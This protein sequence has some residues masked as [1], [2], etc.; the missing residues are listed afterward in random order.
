MLSSDQVVVPLRSID[1]GISRWIGVVVVIPENEGELCL[2]TWTRTTCENGIPIPIAVKRLQEHLKFEYMH[3]IVARSLPTLEAEEDGNCEEEK[4]VEC[5]GVWSRWSFYGMLRFPH[6]V[7]F[8]TIAAKCLDAM[9]ASSQV[10]TTVEC[11]RCCYVVKSIHFQIFDAQDT[12]KPVFYSAFLQNLDSKA[13]DKDE[14]SHKKFPGTIFSMF[15]EEDDKPPQQIG[16]KRLR[17]FQYDGIVEDMTQKSEAVSEGTHQSLEVSPNPLKKA[18]ATKHD[19]WVLC[20]EVIKAKKNVWEL[21]PHILVRHWH[22]I[23]DMMKTYAPSQPTKP[24]DDIAQLRDSHH[25][26]GL[27]IWGKPGCGKS[28]WVRSYLHKLGKSYY[29]KDIRNHWF[30]GYTDQEVIFL[31]DFHRTHRS[32]WG[33]WL[34]GLVNPNLGDTIVEV[35]GSSVAFKA[36]YWIVTSNWS[37]D[38]LWASDSNDDLLALKRR[39]RQI[40]FPS[41]NMSPHQSHVHELKAM[42]IPCMRR[43]LN[44]IKLARQSVCAAQCAM[45]CSEHE[46]ALHH[47]ISEELLRIGRIL[48]PHQRHGI[49]CR[50]CRRTLRQKFDRWCEARH[51]ESRFSSRQ[52]RARLGTIDNS[53]TDHDPSIQKFSFFDDESGVHRSLG[54]APFEV[55]ETGRPESEVSSDEGQMRLK[56][57]RVPRRTSVRSNITRNEI[58]IP[59]L[60]KQPH[61]E[62]EEGSVTPKK[63]STPSEI[64]YHNHNHYHHHYHHHHHYAEEAPLFDGRYI[65]DSYLDQMSLEQDATKHYLDGK[66]KKIGESY[67]NK[68]KPR[69]VMTFWRNVSAKHDVDMSQGLLRRLVPD[70]VA[71]DKENILDEYLNRLQELGTRKSRILKQLTGSVDEPRANQAMMKQR[72]QDEKRLRWQEEAPA[73]VAALRSALPLTILD[74]NNLPFSDNSNSLPLTT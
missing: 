17:Q 63:V 73:V 59:Q 47:E 50:K 8:T 56:K 28:T 62:D 21:P 18:G 30:D 58:E 33:P 66:L 13:S 68:L 20:M 46:H 23:K 27:W 2:Q 70:S 38:E 54:P 4:A 69:D 64:H 72:R 51:I 15:M 74:H 9:Q 49:G 7:R 67:I 43:V 16:V 10:L 37:L 22:Q 1:S 36:D 12:L 6:S 45:P 25:V 48:T 11:K 29:K 60:R 26:R 14:R 19:D 40:H 61:Y 39:F 41:L 53:S 34:K 31:D 52:Q 3:G 32:L 5:A 71:R 42:L 57:S 35:K 65:A 24:Y 55:D 44:R